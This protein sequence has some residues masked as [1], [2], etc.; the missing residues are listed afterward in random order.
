VSSNLPKTNQIFERFLPKA[1]KW[2]KKIYKC[3]ILSS[4]LE[5]TMLFKSKLP[6]ILV[7]KKLVH[8]LKEAVYS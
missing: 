6:D 2:V 5:F 4:D 7:T 1:L 8:V 3:E